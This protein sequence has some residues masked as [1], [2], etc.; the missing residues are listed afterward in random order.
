MLEGH[1]EEFGFLF[2][3]TRIMIE[4][5]EADSKLHVSLT[6]LD[7]TVIKF[8]YHSVFEIL[9]EKCIKAMNDFCLEF[10]LCPFLLWHLTQTRD[11]CVI[12][13]LLCLCDLS[14]VN[15][16]CCIGSLNSNEP[17]NKMKYKITCNVSNLQSSTMI[18][19][20]VGYF[21]LIRQ[22][23]IRWLVFTPGL[24]DDG[25]FKNNP[26]S[27]PKSFSSGLLRLWIMTRPADYPWNCSIS[28]FSGLFIICYRIFE[29]STEL[30]CSSD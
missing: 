4:V 21:E 29:G 9:E 22:P 28:K 16:C 13:H 30:A 5:D 12:N 10:N 20:I 27:Y 3:Q 14:W 15:S 1:P 23:W 26:F 17:K 6:N 11:A 19:R 18:F 24:P 2:Q 7:L 8:G 25:S